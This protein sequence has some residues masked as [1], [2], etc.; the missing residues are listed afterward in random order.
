MARNK[1]HRTSLR[2][3]GMFLLDNLDNIFGGGLVVQLS[4]AQLNNTP[5][6]GSSLD[7]TMPPYVGLTI[8]LCVIS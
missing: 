6:M 8:I 2:S 7:W 3:N 5:I 1:I 4:L